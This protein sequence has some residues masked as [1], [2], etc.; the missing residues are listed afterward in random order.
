ML[1]AMESHPD[2]VQSFMDWALSALTSYSAV[3][4]TLPQLLEGLVIVS[5][6]ALELQE[7][8]GLQKSIQLLVSCMRRIEELGN[9]SLARPTLTCSV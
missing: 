1:A 4:A 8:V 5:I 3:L 7:R 6:R 2:L 9:S